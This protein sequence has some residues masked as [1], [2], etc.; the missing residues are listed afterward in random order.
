MTGKVQPIQ[1]L[2]YFQLI[3]I[4]IFPVQGVEVE[5][6]LSGGFPGGTIGKEPACQCRR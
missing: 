4:A 1:N 5:C 3:F 2:I 6:Y